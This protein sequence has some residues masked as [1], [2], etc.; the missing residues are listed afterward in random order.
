VIGLL[1]AIAAGRILSTVVYQA[2]PSDPAVL[3]AVV[4]LFLA[5]GVLSSLAPARRSLRTEPMQALRPD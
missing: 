3:A 2:S 1:L 5:V 4:G